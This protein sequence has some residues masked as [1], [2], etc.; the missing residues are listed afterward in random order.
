MGTINSEG[1]S[2]IASN[3][4]G[5]ASYFSGLL[6]VR[7]LLTVGNSHL[8]GIITVLLNRNTNFVDEGS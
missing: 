2:G 1:I 4:I 5:I 3:I 8:S 7:K 6:A